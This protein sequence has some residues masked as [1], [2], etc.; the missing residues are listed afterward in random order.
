MM[1]EASS[2]FVALDV[3]KNYLV[4]GAVDAQLDVVLPPRRV[5]LLQFESWARKHLKATDAVV[6]EATTNAWYVHDLLEPLVDR[7]VVAHPYHVKLIAASL[8]KT[9]KRDTLALARILAANMVPAV[10]VPPVHVRDLRALVSHRTRL[11]RQRTAAKNRLRSLLHRHHIVPPSGAISSVESRAWWEGLPLSSSEKL[12]ARQDLALIDYLSSPIAEVE[13]ELARL[14]SSDPWADQ[15]PFL[16][17]LPGIGM[18]TAMTV[19]SAIGDVTR[20]P[21]AK[22][23]VGYGGLGARIHASGQTNRSGRIT[24]Q[25]RR[26]LRAAMV[27]AAWVA[28]RSHPFWKDKFEA[29]ATRIGKQKAIVAIAR[30]LLVVV[31]HVLTEQ[32]VDRQADPETVARSLMTWATRNRL[33][34]SLGLSRP[35]FVRLR[36]DQLGIGQELERFKY[37]S[38]ICLLP[39]AQPASELILTT[40]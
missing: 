26:E 22:K 31:W 36:L 25:G 6:F 15:V 29:L 40:G 13:A 18:L 4:V 19:L 34:T 24:K 20:F 12:R 8:V 30:K 1:S 7:V 16:V 33:A 37:G 28:V 3:H 2:R 11:V 39:P 17:Q 10:W 32:A 35:Q 23:L 9:D 21:T 27:E 5:S 38:S 14:S